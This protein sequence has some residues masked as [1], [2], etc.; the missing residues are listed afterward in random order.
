MRIVAGAATDV[1]QVRSLNEDSVLMSATVFAVADGMGGHRG[2]EVAS[3]L[4]LE[5][6]AR[7]FVQPDSNALIHAVQAANAAVYA[8]AGSHP[9]VAGMGTTVVAVGVVRRD[10]LDRLTVVNIGDSRAYLANASGLHQLSEDHSLV[11]ALVREGRLTEEQAAAHPQRN[12]V[13]RALGIEARVAVDA[14][15]LTPSSGD[16]LLLCS[17][18]LF[19]E[20]GPDEIAHLLGSEPDP[21]RAV[22]ALVAAANS[23][24]A[25]DNVSAVVM[26]VLDATTPSDLEPSFTRL[27]APVSDLGLTE[28]TAPVPRVVS[29]PPVPAAGDATAAHPAPDASL[30]VAPGPVTA[31]PDASIV[32]V[33]HQVLAVPSEPVPGAVAGPIVP[34]APLR[35]RFP[36]RIAAF[37]I[38]LMVIVGAAGG[39]VV[40]AARSAYYVKLDRGEVVVFKGRPGG[41]LWF[42]PTVDTRTGIRAASIPTQLQN[43]ELSRAGGHP[44]GSRQEALDYVQQL[45]SDIANT[46]TTTS[47]TSTTVPPATSTLTTDTTTTVLGP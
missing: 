31:D 9:E 23:R 28:D 33:P 38:A 27:T 16:R 46:T 1:G 18:G 47:T 12:V 40:Y 35:R 7:S 22:D 6:L 26:H 42:D 21:Q 11:E 13:T 41:L 25:R 32:G 15:E 2:G 8:H 29:P 5:T 30:P 39:A 43:A 19:N 17:D 36:W 10:G 44:A 37:V 34:P 20:L 3:S 24:G 14:W 45:E 4:A